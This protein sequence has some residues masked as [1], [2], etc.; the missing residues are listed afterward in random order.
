MADQARNMME[1]QLAQMVRL[2]DDLLD[3]SRISRG[4]IELKKERVEL[5]KVVQHAIETSRPLFDQA[6]HDLKIDVPAGP[7]YVDADLTRLAQVFSNLMLSS[8]LCGVQPRRA[9]ISADVQREC[10]ISSHVR[11]PISSSLCD[12]KSGIVPFVA[13]QPI[14]FA[15]LAFSQR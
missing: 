11:R 7:A 3:L 4:K 9:W 14:M 1:R 13:F 2:I 12:S 8:S 6:G 15:Y 5:A 10:H